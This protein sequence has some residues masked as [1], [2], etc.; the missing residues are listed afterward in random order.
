MRG[1]AGGGGLEKENEG[2]GE[3]ELTLVMRIKAS[4]QLPHSPGQTGSASGPALGLAW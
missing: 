4:A 3:D 1:G 2:M